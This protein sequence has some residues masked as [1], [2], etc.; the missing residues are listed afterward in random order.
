MFPTKNSK[1]VIRVTVPVL[2]EHAAGAQYHFRRHRDPDGV[3]HLE[4]QRKLDAVADLDRDVTGRR[5]ADDFV[6][7]PRRL[8]TRSVEIR[9]VA[10]QSTS[11]H[12]DREI[13]LA[14]SA[15]RG[16]LASESFVPLEGL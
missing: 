11:L 9:T 2:L 8:P 15:N 13:A 6:H 4:V 16:T 5:A 1:R 3:G 10:R 14:L 12:V 7:Q